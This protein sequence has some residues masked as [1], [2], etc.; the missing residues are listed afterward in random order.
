MSLP[1][2]RGVLESCPC[3]YQD[4]G[5]KLDFSDVPMVEAGTV[6]SCDKCKRFIEVVGKKQMT[7]LTI[8]PT[9]KH[10]SGLDRR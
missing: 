2:T 6:V 1:Q 10:G 4:C 9:A 3:P 8:R 7:V 5:Y